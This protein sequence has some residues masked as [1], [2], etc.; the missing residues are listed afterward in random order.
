MGDLSTK[1]NAPS[2]SLTLAMA[3]FPHEGTIKSLPLGRLGF[4]LG[5]PTQ[6]PRLLVWS[7]MSL[8]L[9]SNS[10][11]ICSLL[12][13]LRS[14]LASSDLARQTQAEV[15][16]SVTSW[17]NNSIVSS[18][19]KLYNRRSSGH[20]VLRS[21]FAGHWLFGQSFPL[22]TRTKAVDFSRV[23]CRAPSN[24]MSN[25]VESIAAICCSCFLSNYPSCH[26]LRPQA[27]LGQL[28]K[29][30]Q[31]PKSLAHIGTKL[32]HVI[33]VLPDC[34][35]SSGASSLTSSHG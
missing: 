30:H 24:E 9:V 15:V 8:W 17:K 29:D 6:H 31:G 25:Q 32:F 10:F 1:I 22:P 3:V 5:K 19:S 33:P 26:T 2:T 13:G 34:D 16:V 12:R 23:R 21:E 35:S 28:N 11:Q 20:V 4:A 27:L 7:N 18:T 14:F